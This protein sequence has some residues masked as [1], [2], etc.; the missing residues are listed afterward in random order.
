MSVCP[1]GRCGAVQTG[2]SSATSQ[3]KEGTALRPQLGGAGAQFVYHT[4]GVQKRS[5]QQKDVSLLLNQSVKTHFGGEDRRGMV[6]LR[7]GSY[8]VIPC[9]QHSRCHCMCCQ[10]SKARSGCRCSLAEPCWLHPS[11]G[12]GAAVCI[13]TVPPTAAFMHHD[14]LPSLP[15]LHR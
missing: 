11:P 3:P 9:A 15:L 1:L 2:L 4:V 14:V 13:T 10:E 7:L 6:V 8:K 12:A 5:K